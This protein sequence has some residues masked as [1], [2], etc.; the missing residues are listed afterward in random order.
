[1]TLTRVSHSGLLQLQLLLMAAYCMERLGLSNCSTRSFRDN[2]SRAAY[3]HS[4]SVFALRVPTLTHSNLLTHTLESQSSTYLRSLA[5][6]AMTIMDDESEYLVLLSTER[7]HTETA[8]AR[9]RALVEACQASRKE[10]RQRTSSLHRKRFRKGLQRVGT[11]LQ[12]I[13]I[14]KWIDDLEKDQEAAD[15]LDRVNQENREEQ[16]RKDLC[17]QAEQACLLA[18]KEHL[19]SF[20]L[21]K[22]DAPYEEWISELHPDNIKDDG[23]GTVDPRFYIQDSDHRILWND[24]MTASCSADS[25]SRIVKA[26]RIEL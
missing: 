19:Q 9:R 26:R 14:A 5:N 8:V 2:G 20:L 1:M 18:V 22:A 6:Y 11:A 3:F 25:L 16:E 4:P 10:Q 15:E 7:L 17:R 13:N 23:S 24:A 21:E 12:K